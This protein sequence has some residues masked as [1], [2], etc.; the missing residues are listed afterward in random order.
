MTDSKL[1]LARLTGDDLGSGEGAQS[2]EFRQVLGPA[3]ASRGLEV[4]PI[5]DAAQA[6]LIMYG[7]QASFVI[8]YWRI[9]RRKEPGQLP[10]G[11]R[12]GPGQK[13]RLQTGVSADAPFEEW[14]KVLKTF[15][16][17]ESEI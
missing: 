1:A 7:C 8:N 16:G 10:V 15:V 6:L 11:R 12:L 2:D 14:Q 4:P 13:Y 9:T 3:P 17:E 5:S